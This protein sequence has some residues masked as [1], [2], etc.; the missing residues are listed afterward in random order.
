MGIAYAR[1]PSGKKYLLVYGFLKEEAIMSKPT[2][3][4]VKRRAGRGP[5]AL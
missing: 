5:V 2:S 4:W 3:T 1:N